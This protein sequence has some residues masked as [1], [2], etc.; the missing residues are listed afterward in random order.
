MYIVSIIEGIIN[1]SIFTE[2]QIFCAIAV[3]VE[4]MFA[5]IRRMAGEIEG[6]K[7]KVS[8]GEIKAESLKNKATED[9]TKMAEE[10]NGQGR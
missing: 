6:L 1:H 8:E 5:T 10:I 9:D 4:E 3:Q 2:Q 7:I